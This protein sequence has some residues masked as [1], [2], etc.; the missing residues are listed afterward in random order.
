MY[1]WGDQRRDQDGDSTARRLKALSKVRKL[2][3]L[4]EDQD[5]KPEGLAARRRAEALMEE[6]GL[7]RA[8]LDLEARMAADFRHGEVQLGDSSAWRR[9]LMHAIADYFDCVALYQKDSPSAETFGPEHAL[10]QLGY[11]LMVYLRQLQRAW[12]AHTG[13]LMEE[14]VWGALSRRQQLDTKESFCVSFVLGV[15]ERLELD[16]KREQREDPVGWKATQQQRRDLD[17]WMRRGGVRWRS[18]P[19]GVGAFSD[20]GFR[21]GLEAE[22]DQGLGRRGGPR[23]VG[24][25]HRTDV[26][27]K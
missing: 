12:T 11:T 7:Q 14:A 21:A 6:Y 16:R 9:T 3:R 18:N 15:K 20:E 19:S 26:T 25:R 17:R 2:L 4:A 23:M 24:T 22:V 5:G 10:P 1:R 27:G 13:Q 8:S